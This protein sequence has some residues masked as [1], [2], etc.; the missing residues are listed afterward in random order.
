MLVK[1]KLEKAIKDALKSYTDAVSDVLDKVG[2]TDENKSVSIN[3]IAKI[4]K[5][6]SNDCASAIAD[7]VDEY[8]KSA[9]ITLNVG[10]LMTPM[11]GLVSPV[12][13]VTGVITLAAP[14]TLTD[15]IS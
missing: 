12:G 14:T 9:T 13:P 1:T 3:D 2:S 6:A 5:D 10:T 4:F 11:P 8:I 7:A 15:A